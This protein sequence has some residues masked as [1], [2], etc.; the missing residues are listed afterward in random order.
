MRKIAHLRWDWAVDFVIMGDVK[1]D[2]A[3]GGGVAFDAVPITA[4]C[5][6]VP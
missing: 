6:G 3:V 2:D 1:G 5:V 4:V